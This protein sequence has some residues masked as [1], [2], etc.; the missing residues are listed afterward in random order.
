M[1]HARRMIV[2]AS[3]TAAAVLG[4][5][6]CAGDNKAAPAVSTQQKADHPKADHPK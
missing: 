2:L 3:V 5:A 6:A 4:I 1:S